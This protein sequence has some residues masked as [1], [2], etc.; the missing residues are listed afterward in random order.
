M[1]VIL[2]SIC[3]FLINGIHKTELSL[4]SVSMQSTKTPL[5]AIMIALLAKNHKSFVE[6]LVQMVI[7]NFY[8]ELNR[9]CYIECTLRV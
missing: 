8:D 2:E 4:C 6:E 1:R 5:Y 9:G 3:P 7:N